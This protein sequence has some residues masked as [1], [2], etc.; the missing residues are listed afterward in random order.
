M[1]S[2]EKEHPRLWAGAWSGIQRRCGHFN[3]GKPAVNGK[4]MAR[5]VRRCGGM[6]WW[7]VHSVVPRRQIAPGARGR[8]VAGVRAA[9]P[10]KSAAYALWWGGGLAAALPV[11]GWWPS[12]GPNG[13]HKKAQAPE[14]ERLRGGEGALLAGRLGVVEAVSRPARAAGWRWRPARWCGRCSSAS[15]RR[16]SSR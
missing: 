10:A 8:R 14:S 12:D 16:C 4:P 7:A 11:G 1:I 2:Y 5:P 9:W 6:L 15:T 3:G 13:R